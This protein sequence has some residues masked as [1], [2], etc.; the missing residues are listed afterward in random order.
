[1]DGKCCK[2]I[3]I[4]SCN[5]RVG[6]RQIFL[7]II[8][9]ILGVIYG[10]WLLFF[11]PPPWRSIVDFPREFQQQ[12]FLSMGWV[13]LPDNWESSQVLELKGRGMILAIV[14]F[15][16]SQ[17][18]GAGGC[19][20]GIYERDEEKRLRLLLKLLLPKERTL[21]QIKLE[22]QESLDCLRWQYDWQLKSVQSVYCYIGR[23]LIEVQQQIEGE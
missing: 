1:M 16:N 22:R 5:K 20:Y 19:L 17:L 11:T 14:D 13:S 15:N 4:G 23:D 10:G 21:P 3:E 2:T 7:G 8:A 6:K 9:T 18:C 12:I